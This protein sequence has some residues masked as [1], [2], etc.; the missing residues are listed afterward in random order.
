MYFIRPEE[1]ASWH[2]AIIIYVCK[3]GGNHFRKFRKCYIMFLQYL[4][5]YQLLY[6]ACHQYA[7]FFYL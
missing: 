3:E 1:R 7:G 2:I 6:L 5:R 4:T